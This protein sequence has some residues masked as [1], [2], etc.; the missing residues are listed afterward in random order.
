M[1]LHRISGCMSV[2]YIAR[3]ER[4]EGLHRGH[5]S[6]GAYKVNRKFRFSCILA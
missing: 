3:W 4:Q 1:G 5:F 6:D 2:E